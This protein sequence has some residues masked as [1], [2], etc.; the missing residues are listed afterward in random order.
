MSVFVTEK[1][2]LDLCFL[3]ADSL[4]LLSVAVGLFQREGEDVEV[5]TQLVDL[6]K[7]K[8]EIK[9]EL[10]TITEREFFNNLLNLSRK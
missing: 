1:R 5:V 10:I 7:K 3:Q 2:N 6:G 9:I 4:L 8:K